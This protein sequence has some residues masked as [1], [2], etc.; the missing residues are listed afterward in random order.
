MGISEPVT[1]FSG[2]HLRGNER[3]MSKEMELMFTVGDTVVLN[4]DPSGTKFVISQI[5]SAYNSYMDDA[6]HD[7]LL[8]WWHD[9]KLVSE[10]IDARCIRQ[11]AKTSLGF[12]PPEVQFTKENK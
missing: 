6:H 10:W 1:C 5:R 3:K 11:P 9:G 8:T 7:F 4:S 12:V 2:T